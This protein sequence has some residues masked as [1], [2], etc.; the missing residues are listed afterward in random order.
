MK[1]HSLTILH[2]GKDYLTHALRSVYH[3]V[4]YLHVFYT[5]TPSH[6]HSTNI[7]PI[8][9]KKELVQAAYRYDPEEKIR[10]HDMFGVS[11]EGPQ[12]DLALRTV[13]AAGADIVLVVDYE[14]RNAI[15][16]SGQFRRL[17][18]TLYW[19]WIMTRF[20]QLTH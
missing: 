1:I 13:Q 20:G 3:Q 9:T 8:E 2:Y 11:Q 15:W 6:G 5:P 16:H 14:G 10:W 4:D 12:R 19:L 7:P 18:L 17:G